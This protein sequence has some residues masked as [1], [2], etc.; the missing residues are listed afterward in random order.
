[1]S[2]SMRRALLAAGV[3]GLMLFAGRWTATMLADRWWGLAVSP[4]AG[5]FLTDVHLLRLT[6][7]LAGVVIATAWFT[8]NLLVVYR[9]IGGVE[10][11]RQIA[12]GRSSPGPW[13]SASSSASSLAAMCRATG[14]K[15][16]LHGR[17]C[18]SA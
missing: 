11:S 9:A 17:V 5:Q 4:A 16:R 13:C 10:V 3:L 18:S 15:S 6:L 7:D 14:A 12:S 1:M 8:G 2:N